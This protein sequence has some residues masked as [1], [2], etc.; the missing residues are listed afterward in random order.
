[1]TG[2]MLI[3]S[4]PAFAAVLLPPPAACHV[5]SPARFLTD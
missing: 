1:M 3:I 2:M 5:A 4:L